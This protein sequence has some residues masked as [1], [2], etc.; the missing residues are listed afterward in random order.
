MK[1]PER[2]AGSSQA[3]GAALG[4]RRRE[5]P[6]RHLPAATLPWLLL[7]AGC[8]SREGCHLREGARGLEGN[9]APATEEQQNAQNHKMMISQQASKYAFLEKSFT[10]RVLFCRIEIFTGF[11]SFSCSSF[12]SQKKL[13]ES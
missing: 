13:Q 5:N 7:R 9:V 4:T 8:S 6:F 12:Y 1:M 2:P 11:C 3:M 10:I